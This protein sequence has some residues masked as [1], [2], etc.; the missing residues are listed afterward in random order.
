M[1]EE[2]RISSPTLLVNNDGT[3]IDAN[4]LAQE[5]FGY[6]LNELVG[7]SINLLIPASLRDRHNL[8]F[9]KFRNGR[10]NHINCFRVT[11]ISKTGKTVY[12]TISVVKQGQSLL[13]VMKNA[14]KKEEK[15]R[16][17]LAKLG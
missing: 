4:E 17:L 15:E 16:A 5:T 13:A 7:Q 10:A 11:G 9:L 1:T 12:L 6:N 2:I 8:G 3:I 14:T